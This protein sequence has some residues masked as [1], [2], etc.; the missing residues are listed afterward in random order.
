[1]SIQR[2]PPGLGKSAFPTS[3]SDTDIANS[4]LKSDSPLN[5]TQRPNKYLK[6]P[7][8]DDVSYE[9]QLFK[10]EMKE[11]MTS[12]IASQNE[13]MSDFMSKQNDRLVIMEEHIKVVKDQNCSIHTTNQDIEKSMNLLS[14]DIKNIER[15]INTMEQERKVTSENLS[16]MKEKI[17]LLERQSIKTCIEIR[18]VPKK[19][20]ESKEDLFGYI[21]RLCGDLRFQLKESD[22]RDVYRGYS[23]KEI[24]NSSL[25]LE[26]QNTII[27]T[28]LLNSIK[29]YNIQ[30]PQAKLN[31]SNLGFSD[32]KQIIYAS[33]QL[34]QKMKRLFY[35][36]RE[37]AKET[38][39]AFVWSTNG[40]VY[41][42]Q[43]EKAPHI[44]IRSE[45]HI[46]EIRTKC[47]SEAQK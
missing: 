36:S 24:K 26:L 17:E 33:E 29:N 18:N 2:S 3:F 31:S 44:M 47:K 38:N 23:P 45:E 11:L 32:N 6:R 16:I 42:R 5:I 10:A 8:D 30:N 13:R 9:L 20:Y 25:I 39:I 40:R 12:M 14:D 4:T 15:K 21:K 28:R 35:L 34:T 1:M 41:I 37:L 43:N 7:R 46:D 22:V 19:Q 27:K